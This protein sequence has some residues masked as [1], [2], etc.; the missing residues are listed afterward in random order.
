MIPLIRAAYKK[1]IDA[2]E[3]ADP[4]DFDRPVERFFWKP[5]TRR[6][7]YVRLV[8]HTNEHV[9]QLIAYAR[10]MGIAPPWSR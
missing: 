6:T 9:G 3:A 10:T 8:V 2:L 1:A 5:A 4:E 7:V